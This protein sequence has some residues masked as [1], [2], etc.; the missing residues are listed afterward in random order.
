VLRL[1]AALTVTALAYAV[2]LE[3]RFAELRRIEAAYELYPMPQALDV[4]G[5]GAAGTV[6]IVQTDAPN[7]SRQ[8][9]VE[10][11]GRRLLTLPYSHT[12]GTFRTH[13]AARRDTIPMRLVVYDG[14]RGPQNV[15][16]DAYAWNGHALVRDAPDTQD[17]RLLTA[18]AAFD[19]T[20]T[21]HD[22]LRWWML[23]KLVAVVFAAGWLI[24]W[25]CVRRFDRPASQALAA[26]GGPQT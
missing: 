4:D 20:G 9:V 26:D 23:S 5:D 16:R 17:A 1:F 11:G 24:S 18:M 3:W 8:L 13:I 21:F 15:V 10:D 22:W 25:V 19:D 12:D 7:S 2:F 14:A 6:S